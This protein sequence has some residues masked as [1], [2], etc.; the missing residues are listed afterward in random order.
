MIN[1]KGEWCIYKTTLMCQEGYCQDCEILAQF[2]R[3]TDTLIDELWG[4]DDDGR[5]VKS[6]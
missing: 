4:D 6:K 3:D 2:Q 5:A 1:H